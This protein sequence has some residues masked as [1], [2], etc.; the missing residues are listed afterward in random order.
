M[1]A[2]T[3]RY[4]PCRGGR[5]FEVDNLD[6]LEWMGRF[7]GRIHAVAAKNRL[8]L[9]GLTFNSEEMLQ[10]AQLIIEQV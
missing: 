1:K 4:F 3:L 10:Q 9:S 2:I 7:L 6:Q 8:H 5:I